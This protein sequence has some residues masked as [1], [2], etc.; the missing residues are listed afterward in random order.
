M[1][2]R[3]KRLKPPEGKSLR[4]SGRQRSETRTTDVSTVPTRARWSRPQWPIYLSTRPTANH[5]S[6]FRPTSA[7]SADQARRCSTAPEFPNVPRRVGGVP[8]QERTQ[9]DLDRAGEIAC[10]RCSRWAR[11]RENTLKALAVT[12]AEKLGATTGRHVTA[13]SHPCTAAY[14][15]RGRRIRSQ[16]SRPRAVKRRSQGA[17]RAAPQ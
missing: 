11:L 13:R 9:L 12:R 2:I 7:V 14:A 3:R 6:H 15:A 8:Q 10:W 1:S 16:A 5:A 17:S 4:P